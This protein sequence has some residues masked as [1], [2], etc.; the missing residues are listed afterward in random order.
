MKYA[1]GKNA[2]AVCDRCGLRAPYKMLVNDGDKPGLRVHPS[3][4]DEKHPAEKPFNADEGIAL[5]NPRPDR[6][7]DSVGDSGELLV[8][9][10]F[11]NDHNFGGGT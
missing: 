4:R 5:K 3:C 8:E 6:D 7:D 11:P 9:A 2:L 1:T 10:L